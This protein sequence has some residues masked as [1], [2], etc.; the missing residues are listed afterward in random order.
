M[1]KLAIITTHPIQYYAPVFE[2]LHK[3]QKINTKVFYTRGE[4]IGSS[5]DH[6]FN[7]PI[8][9][10]IPLLKG[11]EFEWLKNISKDAGSHHFKGIINPRAIKQIEAWQPDAILVFGWAYHSHLKIIRYF[12]GK[13]PV[14]FRGDSTLLKEQ[15]RL[16][17]LLRLV[18]LKW[19]YGHISHAFY[20]G[21][22]NKAYFERYGLKGS[23]LSFAPHAIDNSRFEIDR[24][25]EADELRL[26]LALTDQDILILYAGKFEPVKNL[27]LLLSA[28]I[29]INNP[30]VHLLLVGNGPG[31]DM[32][33]DMAHKTHCE[34]H[35]HFSDFKNQTYM[36]VLYQ[37]CDLFCL[38]SKS[39]TWGLSVNEAM[40]CGKAILASDNVGCAIDLV[41]GGRNG[42]IFKSGDFDDL[43][44]KLQQLT[45]RKAQLTKF[46]LESRSVIKDW[47]FLH[48][49]E[50]I[51]N[52][53][54]NETY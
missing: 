22:N 16:K 6:G 50:A 39:E 29:Q 1:N 40:A 23:H 32:L 17:R 4:N 26:S 38:P 44:E 45:A 2:L 36:P 27:E 15:G 19:L 43:L 49:A 47:G 7:K 53:L 52:K 10:D 28:F 51:E 20:V 9:W 8:S 24:A 13:L 46:G 3:R 33:K 35:I 14:Y 54:L 48:I 5:H 25:E 21:K 42:A 31:Q 34:S 11:Y 41:K 30:N 12:K 37:G 18:F